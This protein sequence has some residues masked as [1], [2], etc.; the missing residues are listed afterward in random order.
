MALGAVEVEVVKV[1]LSST[2]FASSGMM[3]TA[4]M[5]PTA[6]SGMHVGHVEK[7]GSWVNPTRPQVQIA[8]MLGEEE[9]ISVPSTDLKQSA[10]NNVSMWSTEEYLSAHLEVAKSGRYNFQ[11]CRIPIPTKIRYDLIR[12]ALADCSTSRDQLVLE[13]LEFGM[14]IGCK[15][16]YGVSKAQ[17]N[18]HS[19]LGFKDAISKY[20]GKGIQFQGML[21]PFSKPPIAGLC[22]SPLMTVPKEV[23]ERRIIVD[24]S[25]PPGSS[26]ND[27]IS[28][29][30]YL[31][32]ETEF[33]LP[34]I[35]SMVQR[36]NYLGRGCL[37]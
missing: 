31:N 22:F 6:G 14:P 28:Q 13:L 26:V 3:V 9:V 35:Q 34:S 21:G 24:F 12:E 33:N 27:G 15:P 37:L 1:G 23:D 16:G 10:P 4:H 29:S 36:M 5:G 32:C 2:T 25:F 30:V 8:P 20:L 19:A 18:H 17:K 7:Q 11:G